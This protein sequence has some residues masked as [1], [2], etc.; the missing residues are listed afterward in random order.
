L[1]FLIEF[2]TGSRH[3]DGKATILNVRVLK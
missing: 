3:L 1:T 2:L